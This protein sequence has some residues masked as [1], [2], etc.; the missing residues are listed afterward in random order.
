MVEGGG[1]LPGWQAVVP[2]QEQEQQLRAAIAKLDTILRNPAELERNG[3]G[4][5]VAIKNWSVQFGSLKQ[6][7]ENIEFPI[8]IS[9]FVIS[10]AVAS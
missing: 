5:A 9:I 3:G 1:L 8:F 4:E 2:W 10:Q 7:E 6:E